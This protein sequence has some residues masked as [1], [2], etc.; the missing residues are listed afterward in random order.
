MQKLTPGTIVC[1]RRERWRVADVR[2]YDDCQVVTV[3]GIGSASERRFL[4]PFDLVDPVA[5]RTA[6]RGVRGSLWRRACRAAVAADTPPGSLRAA[7]GAGI[8]L[9]PHQLAPALAVAR[10]LG[11]RLLLADEVGLGKTI[12]AGLIVAELRAR[13]A[14][15]R[16]LV[17]TP[18]GLR[19]QWAGE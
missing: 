15:D 19:D 13:D 11:C 17:L 6:A 5:R 1:V 7:A 10:G 9:L 3:S 4:T 14:A 16:V 2:A 12:Q 18:A 8:D